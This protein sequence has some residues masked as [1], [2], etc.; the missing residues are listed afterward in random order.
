MKSVIRQ[1]RKWSFGHIMHARAAQR[2]S[3]LR[4]P[5]TC[6][7][8]FDIQQSQLIRKFGFMADGYGH[9]YWG[10]GFYGGASF[11]NGVFPLYGTPMQHGQATTSNTACTSGT[12]YYSSA[13]TVTPDVIIESGADNS[14][15]TVDSDEEQVCF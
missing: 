4:R 13:S 15:H 5:R 6:M 3:A 9:P 2:V 11:P 14:D 12:P 1:Y 7:I 8:K 10:G